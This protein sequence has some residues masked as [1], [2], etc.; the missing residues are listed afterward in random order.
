MPDEGDGK[1]M[2]KE[3]SLLPEVVLFPSL[4]RL[5]DQQQ[6]YSLVDDTRSEHMR[7]RNPDGRMSIRRCTP[8]FESPSMKFLNHCKL[9]GYTYS[10]ATL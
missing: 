10:L 7:E 8:G 4:Y 3:K 1:K 9:Y 6:S 2:K 5:L